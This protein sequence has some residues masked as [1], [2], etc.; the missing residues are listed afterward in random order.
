MCEVGEG[1]GWRGDDPSFA[2]FCAAMRGR[3]RLA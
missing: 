2:F 1:R 3:P